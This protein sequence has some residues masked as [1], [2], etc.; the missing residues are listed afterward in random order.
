MTQAIRTKILEMENDYDGTVGCFDFYE[1]KDDMS[2]DDYVKAFNSAEFRMMLSESLD[3]KKIEFERLKKELGDAKLSLRLFW[4]KEYKFMLFEDTDEMFLELRRHINRI[5]PY[6]KVKYNLP[7]D[8]SDFEIFWCW[9]WWMYSLMKIF[10][11][12][13]LSDCIRNLEVSL[14]IARALVGDKPIQKLGN[15]FT[16][17][18]IAGANAISVVG[19]VSGKARITGSK[20]IMRCPFHDEKTGSFVIYADNSWHCFGCNAHGGGAIDFIMRKDNLKFL[21]AVRSLI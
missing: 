6:V 12:R 5:R 16:A 4:E 15:G 17:D 3:Q 11:L 20:T 7:D 2:L 18:Q 9:E 13:V 1:H 8:V 19:L 21:E 10:D 14:R